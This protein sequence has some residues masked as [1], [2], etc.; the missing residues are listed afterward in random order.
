MTVPGRLLHGGSASGRVLKLDES[1][2]FWGGFDAV[3]GTIIDRAHPQAGAVLAG[4]IVAM[5]GS[6]GSSGTPGVLGEA[7]RRG[8]A[9]AGLIVTTADVNL[10]SGALVGEELYGVACPILLVDRATYEGLHDGEP[11]TLGDGP[12]RHT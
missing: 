12:A 6:R 8:T 3:T 9:P 4:R 5:P 11:V 2:S 1:L 10:V 7:L